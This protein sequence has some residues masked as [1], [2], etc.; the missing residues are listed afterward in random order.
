MVIVTAIYRSHP[1]AGQPII[2]IRL[3]TN[4]ADDRGVTV[5]QAPTTGFGPQGPAA[6]CV[7]VG[8]SGIQTVLLNDDGSYVVLAGAHA[9]PG[10]PLLVA[11]PGL[12]TDGRVVIA[13]N[14]GWFDVDPA[15]ELGLAGPAHLLCNDAEAAALG[16]SV[17]RPDRPELVFVGLGT[18]VGAATVDGDDVT[19]NLIAHG[20]GFG[21]RPCRCGE[22]GCLETVAGGW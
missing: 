20:G 7:D 22:T 10:R 9:E 13:S 11:A 19:P 17:L 18:G 5:D 4:H 15:D 14:L 2:R 21:D 16:E 6:T 3:L 1:H 8:G 12:H